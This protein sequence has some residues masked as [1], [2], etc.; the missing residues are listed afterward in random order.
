MTSAIKVAN[1]IKPSPPIWIK[2]IIISFPKA[3]HVLYVA[4]VTK[5]VTHTEDVAVNRQSM[6]GTFVAF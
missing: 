6:Y 3:L 1:V 5:P 2:M 4:T